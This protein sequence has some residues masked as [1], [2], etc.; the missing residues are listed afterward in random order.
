[1]AGRS[2]I[3]FPRTGTAGGG[4]RCS[5]F[6][7]GKRENVREREEPEFVFLPSACPPQ[8]DR[9]LEGFAVWKGGRPPHKS[10]NGSKKWIEYTVVV[11]AAAEVFSQRHPLAAERRKRRK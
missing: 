4:W 2:A 10:G 3:L 6:L 9:D 11:C 7:G 8:F 5:V 1:M